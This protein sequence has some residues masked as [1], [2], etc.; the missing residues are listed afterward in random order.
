MRVDRAVAPEILDRPQPLGI[1][2]A[3]AAMEAQGQE[4][5]T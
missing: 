2:A 3:V 1:E 5:C 4:H